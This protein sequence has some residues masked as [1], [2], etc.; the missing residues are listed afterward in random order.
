MDRTA[1][2]GTAGTGSIPVG[3]AR[4]KNTLFALVLDAARLRKSA[5]QEFFLYTGAGRLICAARLTAK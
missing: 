2:S 4:A 3:G 1:V 5:I